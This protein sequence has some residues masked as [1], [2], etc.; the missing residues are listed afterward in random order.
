[1]T[2]VTKSFYKE[3][4]TIT[5]FLIGIFLL[6]VLKISLNIL[7]GANIFNIFFDLVLE[8]AILGLV[9]M[10]VNFVWKYF[11]DEE[12]TREI[13]RHDLEATKKIAQAFEKKSQGLVKEFQSYVHHEFNQWQLSQSEKEISLLILEGL[14]SKD[15]SQ[16]RFTSERTIRNQC[17]AIYQKSKLAGK[18][19]FCAYFLKEFLKDMESN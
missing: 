3:K 12:Q 15:M 4:L 13:I 7:T 16:K 1:M 18:N 6:V 11:R 10:M 5:Y 17:A 8:L 19:D 9:I 2:N 14:S